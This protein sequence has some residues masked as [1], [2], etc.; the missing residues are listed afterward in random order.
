MRNF[1]AWFVFGNERWKVHFPFLSRI[2]VISTPAGMSGG[3]RAAGSLFMVK[4]SPSCRNG[5]PPPSPF[6]KTSPRL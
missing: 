4:L 1:A 2:S 3:R 5:L 6:M